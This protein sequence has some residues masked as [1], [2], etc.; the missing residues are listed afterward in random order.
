MWFRAI[1]TTQQHRADECE[2]PDLFVFIGRT[3]AV[4]AYVCGDDPPKTL[5]P[6]E[7]LSVHIDDS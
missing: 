4:E 2:C 6:F 7:T 1:R 3:L 5:S